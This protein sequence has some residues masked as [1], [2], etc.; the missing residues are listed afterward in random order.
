MENSSIKE[1]KKQFSSIGLLLFFTTLL[2]YGVQMATV[3]IIGLIPAVA[4]NANLSFIIPMLAMYL[5]A[6]PIV[7]FL[8][9]KLPAQKAA[10]TKKLRPGQFFTS[11]FIAYAATYVGNIVAVLL[12]TIVSLFT[13][14]PVQNVLANVVSSIHPL[15][16]LFIVVICAP[17]MEELLFRKAVIDHTVKY[18]EGIAIIF[19]ALLFGLFH[20]NLQQFIYAFVLGMIFGYV[21]VKTRKIQYTM[22]LHMLINFVGSFISALVME[23]TNILELSEQLTTHPDELTTIMAENLSSF[24]IYY[25]YLAFIF[26]LVI[27]GIILFFVNLKKYHLDSGEVTIEKGQRFSVIILNL[28]MI[29][30]LLFWIVQIVIQLLGINLNQ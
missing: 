16:T 20:G 14:N 25:G 11:L 27:V 23:K 6:F 30:Y 22:L 3:Q 28:G 5:I 29:L 9:S 18:G 15:V 24:V 4:A 1:A 26:I 7:L 10:E 21:Y 19:S 13:K 12:T 8:F 17:I 2:V